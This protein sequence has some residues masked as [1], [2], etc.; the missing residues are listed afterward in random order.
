M[1]F[2]VIIPTY[3]RREL[4]KRAVDSVLNQT[5][6]DFEVIIVDDGSTD[7]TGDY[8]NGLGDKRIRY[9]FQFNQGQNVATN[10]GIKNARGEVIAFLDSDDYWLKDKL[11]KT[12]E[13]YLRNNDVDVVYHWTGLE[14]NGEIVLAREDG[15]EGY[16]YERVLKAGYLTSP[17]FL[18]CRRKCFEKIGLLDEKVTNCQDDDLCFA[19]C[20]DFKVGLIREIL[21]VYEDGSHMRDRIT[22]EKNLKN[23]TVSE[24]YFWN[25]WRNEIVRIHGNELMIKRYMDCSYKFL[26][27]HETELAKQAFEE[28]K[29][30]VNEYGE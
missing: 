30:L 9:F 12:Y 3:N 20:R 2:S 25:K 21:G 7:N 13:K 1:F 11:K 22:D 28:A 4:L 5:F 15:F 24:Y 8:I 18:T 17:T 19:L 23:N 14:R 16:C 29:Q 6:E 27:C 10:N 26:R